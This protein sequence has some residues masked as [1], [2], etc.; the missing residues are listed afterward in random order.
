MC[1]SCTEHWQSGDVMTILKSGFRNSFEIG[2][3]LSV[4]LKSIWLK[5]AMIIKTQ[6]GTAQSLSCFSPPPPSCLCYP[7]ITCSPGHWQEICKCQYE[8]FL[9]RYYSR[10]HYWFFSPLKNILARYLRLWNGPP[11]LSRIPDGWD[12]GSW[13]PDVSPSL[14]S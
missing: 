7:S 11:N 4:P 1:V 5:A 8:E 14:P 6:G 2:P 10:Q 12:S 13:C 9:V 3:G